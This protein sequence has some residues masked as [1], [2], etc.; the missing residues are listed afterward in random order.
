MKNKHVMFVA[1]SR[2]SDVGPTDDKTPALVGH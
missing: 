2:S 1:D